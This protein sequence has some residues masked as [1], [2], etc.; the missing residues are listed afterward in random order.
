MGVRVTNLNLSQSKA[1]ML[2]LNQWLSINGFGPFSKDNAA[3]YT[4][5]LNTFSNTSIAS[6]WSGTSSN[7]FQFL[8][9]GST[10]ANQLAVMSGN[11]SGLA[12]RPILLPFGSGAWFK[13]TIKINLG[14]DPVFEAL[15]LGFSTNSSTAAP[16]D[17]S[18]FFGFG[19]G[20]GDIW[21]S[22]HISSGFL[23]ERPSWV[24]PGREYHLRY[25]TVAG[26]F[27]Y[28]LVGYGTKPHE[29]I[30]SACSDKL[31]FAFRPDTV[32]NIMLELWAPPCRECIRRPRRN[33]NSKSIDQH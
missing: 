12:T 3:A 28:L 19:I 24:R 7:G 29:R 4:S 13:T 31:G 15:W 9:L 33:S 14:T 17:D 22:R 23:S 16:S 26:F 1:G 8:G 18:K 6:T 21:G 11:T 32:S 10:N 20:L 2:P 25:W 27:Q 30:S 5:W